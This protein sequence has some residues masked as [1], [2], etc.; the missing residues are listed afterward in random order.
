MGNKEHRYPARMP[1]NFCFSLCNCSMNLKGSNTKEGGDPGDS[2][3]KVN[4]A[5]T[6]A[7]VGV[8]CGDMRVQGVVI[9]SA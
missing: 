9:S 4:R 1:R 6:P 5:G 8:R 3:W 2:R 7:T